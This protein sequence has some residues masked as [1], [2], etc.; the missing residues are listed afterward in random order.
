[1]FNLLEFGELVHK[2]G[3]IGP[4]QGQNGDVRHDR[5]VKR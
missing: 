5:T 3:W 2:A 4:Y 1:V